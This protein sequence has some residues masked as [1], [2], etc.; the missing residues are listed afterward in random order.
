MSNEQYEAVLDSA[1]QA[2]QESEKRVFTDFT[3]DS[4]V[5]IDDEIVLRK[6][7]EVFLMEECLGSD[8]REDFY[9]GVEAPDFFNALYFIEEFVWTS[10]IFGNFLGRKG[11]VL[12]WKDDDVARK[13]LIDDLKMAQ[14]DEYIPL[15]KYFNAEQIIRVWRDI[16]KRIFL[17]MTD[18]EELVNYLEAMEKCLGKEMPYPSKVMHLGVKT[19]KVFL[20]YNQHIESDLSML[21]QDDVF[22]IC[23]KCF[24]AIHEFFYALNHVFSELESDLEEDVGD[25]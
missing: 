13:L 19:K 17:F 10:N 24:N 12:S 7:L 25:E 14:M 3:V 9:S 18:P 16:V 8:E 11:V 21:Q 23:S 22:M 2:L 5:D 6:I 1:K 4:G 20:V 15:V